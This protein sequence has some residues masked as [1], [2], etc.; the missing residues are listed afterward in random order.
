[1]AKEN[2]WNNNRI[3]QTNYL[4]IF[5]KINYPNKK[6]YMFFINKTVEKKL[7]TYLKNYTT[8][9]KVILLQKI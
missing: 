7:W 2:V 9:Y 5:L 1:M 4:K 6:K 8:N 3:L